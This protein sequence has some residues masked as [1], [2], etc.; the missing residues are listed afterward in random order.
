LIEELNTGR[1]LLFPGALGENFTAERID[2]RSIRLGDRFRAGK[3]VEIR[4]TKIRQP[5]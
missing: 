4:I 3:E 2:C 5:C 1:Y